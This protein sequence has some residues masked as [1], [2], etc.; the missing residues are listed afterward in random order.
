MHWAASLLFALPSHLARSGVTPQGADAAEEDTVAAAGGCSDIAST[1]V[2]L[3]YMQVH[4]KG[5]LCSTIGRSAEASINYASVD[6][7]TGDWEEAY[8]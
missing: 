1:A 4:T 8:M 2:V 6:A 7:A 5:F 3:P